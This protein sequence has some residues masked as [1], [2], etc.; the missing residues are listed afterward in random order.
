MESVI[1][2]T[3]LS[4][5]R[6]SDDDGKLVIERKPLK[7]SPLDD[8]RNL[9]VLLQLIFAYESL[10][11]EYALKQSLSATL[12]DQYFWPLTGRL[13]EN[14]ENELVIDWDSNDENVGKVPFIVA[15]FRGSETVRQL[16][17]SRQPEEFQNWNF[18]WNDHPLKTTNYTGIH[19]PLLAVQFTKFENGSGCVLGV[20]LHHCL[21]DARSFYNFMN[22]WSTLNKNETPLIKPLN[23]RIIQ[24]TS[25]PSTDISLTNHS[26]YLLLPG[27]SPIARITL[28]ETTI[29]MFHF[30]KEYLTRLKSMVQAKVPNEKLSTN[31]VL[32]AHI[33]QK[34]TNV[35]QVNENEI[36]L[37]GFT[38]DIRQ[39]VKPAMDQSYFGNAVIYAMAS[40]HQSNDLSL[41]QLA[42]TVQQVT[43]STEQSTRVSSTLEFLNYHH[44]QGNLSRIFIG[45]KPFYGNDLFLSSW[46][47][48]SMYNAGEFDYGRRPIFVG[49]P[50]SPF[51]DGIGILCRSS[52]EDGSIDLFLGLRKDH[53]KNLNLYEI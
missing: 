48:L 4:Y 8:S 33:W 53:M 23:S 37:L 14:K 12:S 42:N 15:V 27:V 36:T 22:C 39:R 16:F 44:H 5:I 10:L 41:E 40:V 25:S 29:R 11:D 43:S 51:T 34:V 21:A 13:M 1:I 49:F 17:S 52:L 3:N 30:S 18:F 50:F 28:A 47:Q 31:S 32:T 45:W 19:G 24:F 20:Q 9:R 7:L 6:P 35:R 2:Q 46:T 38:M 26:E